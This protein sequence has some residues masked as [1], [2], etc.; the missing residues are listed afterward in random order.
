MIVI[1]EGRV[2]TDRQEGLLA[3]YREG[4]RAIPPQMTRHLIARDSLEPEVIR[5]VSFWDS[6]SGLE[7]Y[8]RHAQTPAALLM[9]RAVGVEPTRTISESL[10]Y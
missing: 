10:E 8:R 9:F 7:E 5:L 4:T 2:P 3:A 6:A 1:W